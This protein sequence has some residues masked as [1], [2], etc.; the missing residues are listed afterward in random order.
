[1]LLARTALFAGMV[2]VASGAAAKTWDLDQLLSF[3]TRRPQAH[4]TTRTPRTAD[5][6]REAFALRRLAVREPKLDV[7]PLRP[8]CVSLACP[9]IIILGVGF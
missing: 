8:G 1:M 3:M 2:L 9:G 6:A 4:A 5:S 7:A